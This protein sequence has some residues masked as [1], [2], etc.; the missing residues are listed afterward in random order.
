MYLS[1]FNS[2]S[3]TPCPVSCLMRCHSF[4]YWTSR[5]VF[6]DFIMFWKHK[7][8][9][10]TFWHVSVCEDSFTFL[11]LITVPALLTH[12]CLLWLETSHTKIILL[13]K[14]CRFPYDV[15][16][17]R[18]VKLIINFRSNL[19]HE[20]RKPLEVRAGVLNPQ[21]SASETMHQTA[22]SPWLFFKDTYPDI[23]LV[24]AVSEIQSSLPELVPQQLY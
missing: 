18:T 14:L 21:S 17:Y 10:M 20:F 12:G 8:C 23:I 16:L 13:R 7:L 9:R 4:S 15:F 22:R 11:R 2:N 3:S 1:N 6:A 24:L 19:G 5:I